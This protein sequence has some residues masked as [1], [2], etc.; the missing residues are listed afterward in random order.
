M[1]E[2]PLRGTGLLTGRAGSRRGGTPR[3]TEERV[4]R[5]LKTQN[6]SMAIVL[7]EIGIT[8]TLLGLALL[9]KRAPSNSGQS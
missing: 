5:H 3:T 6:S 1:G 4:S 8:L 7:I 9:R 2:L